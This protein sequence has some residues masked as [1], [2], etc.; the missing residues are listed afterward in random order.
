M[1]DQKFG[2]LLAITDVEGA[3]LDHFADW[4]DTWLAARERKKGI[5]PGTIARPR[6]YIIKRTFSAFPGEE[7]TP[8]IALISD[9]FARPTRRSGDGKHVAF[10]RIG[11]AAV[12]VAAPEGQAHNLAGHYQAALV[13]IAIGHRKV[14]DG[15]HLV[16]WTDLITDDLD[17]E[18]TGRTMG[19]V[20][21]ELVYQVD[22]FASEFPVLLEIPDEPHQTQPDDP[23]V[24]TTHVEVNKT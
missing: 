13:G 17:E 6:S 11:I 10:I 21:L 19:A 5:V 20:R 23:T 22:G 8:M 2:N 7:Q 14:A 9:G 1:P 18:A 15:I 3:V 12:C 16:E 4:M 24:E